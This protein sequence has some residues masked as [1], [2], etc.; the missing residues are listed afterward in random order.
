M[1][2]KKFG[3]SASALSGS[4]YV[5][6]SLKDKVENFFGLTTVEELTPE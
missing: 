5:I 2:D 6:G 1:P 4:I 3:L